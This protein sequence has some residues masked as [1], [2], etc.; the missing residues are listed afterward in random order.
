MCPDTFSRPVWYSR[1]AAKRVR[2][3]SDLGGKGS[4]R[5]K[6]N[7]RMIYHRSV[8]DETSTV[9]GG[10]IDPRTSRD[11]RCLRNS[12]TQILVD[13]DAVLDQNERM[14]AFQQRTKKSWSRQNI[15]ERSVGVRESV[16]SP[17]SRV[18]RKVMFGLCKI[19]Q[20]T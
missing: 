4:K 10:R 19:A 11:D 13:V 9:D 1:N 16:V 15:R 3:R 17:D 8:L 5:C 14:S 6:K 7:K 2:I 20:L 12:G 18:D